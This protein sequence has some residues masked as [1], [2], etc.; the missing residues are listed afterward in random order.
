MGF[1]W[2]GGERVVG[3]FMLNIILELASVARRRGAFNCVG[4]FGGGRA[5]AAM[6]YCPRIQLISGAGDSDK[7]VGRLCA[8]NIFC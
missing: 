1:V 8:L 5:E 3:C 2:R 7:I 4:T 6:A